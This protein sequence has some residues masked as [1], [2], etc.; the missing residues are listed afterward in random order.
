MLSQAV[1]GSFAAQAMTPRTRV[2]QPTYRFTATEAA[3]IAAA[4]GRFAACSPAEIYAPK[5]KSWM[6]GFLK[7]LAAV[8][9]RT[10]AFGP[11]PRR[12]ARVGRRLG[13]GWTRCPSS[14]R[15]LRGSSALI[16]R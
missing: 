5:E 4:S 9:A 3:T 12:L 7:D 2:A 1:Y 16:A 6:E 11:W 8:R 10:V 15:R 13:R 14:V